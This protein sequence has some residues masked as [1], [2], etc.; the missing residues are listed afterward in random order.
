MTS[1]VNAVTEELSASASVHVDVAVIVLLL[2]L[3]T[4]QELLRAYDRG[5]DGTSTRPLA[6]VVVP[7]LAAFGLIVV[8]R[9]L[10]IR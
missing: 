8:V 4:E 7:L 6:A 10:K 5:S 2:T 1:A 9:V 3:L